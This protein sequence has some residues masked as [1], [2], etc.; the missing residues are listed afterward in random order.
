MA[1]LEA[2]LKIVS[3]PFYELFCGHSISHT[4]LRGSRV[5]LLGFE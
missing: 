4:W 2:C 1:G 3:R 5:L